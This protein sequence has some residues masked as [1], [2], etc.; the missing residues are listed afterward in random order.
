MALLPISQ[1]IK[2][3]ARPETTLQLLNAIKNPFG[4]VSTYVFT[5]SI[6]EHVKDILEAVHDGTGGGY[7]VLSEYGGGKTHFL[8]TVASLLSASD[9]VRDSIGDKEIRQD[10]ALVQGRRLL[11]V[12]FSLIGRAGVVNQPHAL[13]RILEG[14]IQE[15]VERNVGRTLNVSLAS[16]VGQWWDNLATPIKEAISRKC[17]ETRGSAAAEMRKD[18]SPDE[19]ADCIHESA[20]QLHIDIPLQVSPLGRLK[21]IYRQVVNDQTGYTGMLL[22]IDEFASWQDVHP[23]GAPAYSEDESLL[24]TLAE[25]LPKDEGLAVF[26]MVAS[27][28]PMPRKFQG[29]RFK[30]IDVLR[31]AGDETRTSHEYEMVVAER[32]RQLDDQRSPEIE[33]YYEAYRRRFVFARNLSPTDFRSI[34]PVQ[35]LCFD[36]LRRITSNLATA[37]IGINVLWDVLGQEVNGSPQVHPRVSSLTR[38][39]TAADL[40]ESDNL[41]GALT[42]VTYADAYKAYQ[43]AIDGLDRLNMDRDD[44]LPLARS[45]VRTAFL[46]HIARRGQMPMRLEEMAEAVV[47]DE[48]MFGKPEDAV[49]NVVALMQDMP[50]IKYDKAKREFAFRAEVVTGRPVSEILEQYKA[51]YADVHTLE[52]HWREQL[53]ASG[54]SDGRQTALFEKLPPN[55]PGKSAVVFRGVEYPGEEVTQTDWSGHLGQP[56]GFD[57][58]FRVVYLLRHTM[59]TAEALADDRII[60]GIPEELSDQHKEAL[61][62]L[63]ALDK[64]EEEYRHRQ[65]N[66]ALLVREFFHSKHSDF[67][68]AVLTAQRES[69]RKGAIVTKPNLAL[70]P[71]AVFGRS[72]KLEVMLG[73]LFAALFKD[74]PIGAFKGNRAIRM[75]TDV[76][77][78]FTGLWEASPAGKVSDALDNFAVGLGL[79]APQNPRRF[80]PSACPA[81]DIVRGLYQEARS[82]GQ[83][84]QV[85]PLYEAFARC[86]VPARIATLYLLCFVRRGQEGVELVLRE[87][88]KIRL[89]NG[90]PPPH[91]RISSSPV[92]NIV[93]NNAWA[94]GVTAFEA[95]AARSGRIWN[96]SLPWARKVAPELKTAIEPAD[97]ETQQELLLKS[98]GALRDKAES[99]KT[100]LHALEKQTERPVASRITEAL[101]EVQKICCAM[102]FE[103]L[104][105][106][107]EK[108]YANPDEFGDAVSTTGRLYQLSQACAAVAGAFHFLSGIPQGRL[109]GD[110]EVDRK[111]LLERLDTAALVEDPGRWPPVESTFQ[112]WKGRYH[113][114][115]RKFH[116]DYQEEVKKTD[117][118]R[119]EAERKLAAL[120]H[121]EQVPGLATE[122]KHPGLRASLQAVL[123]RLTRC[124]VDVNSLSLETLPH[125]SE[126]QVRY[127]EASQSSIGVV[128]SEID[129]AMDDLLKSF[130]GQAIRKLLEAS[131]EPGIQE[132]RHALDIYDKPRL[133]NLLQSAESVALLKGLLERGKIKV[134]RF[135]VMAHLARDYPTVSRD[136]LDAVV[137]KFKDLVEQALSQAEQ[138]SGTAAHVEVHLQ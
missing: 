52:Q 4:T 129:A 33:E 110:M 74:R 12:A 2:I 65:D 18:S 57:Q 122:K 31:T 49:L 121:L 6:K 25:T 131:T 61:R 124:T 14:E 5:P 115:Y 104:M 90:Q 132:F 79:A 103:D 70:D 133:V 9:K 68:T 71:G 27:Q 95:L 83:Y 30:E 88:H 36:I 59:V 108:Q 55:T 40:M 80:D 76:G 107:A 39:V 10:I 46:W 58:H 64:M 127:G 38:L 135:P 113:R 111:A 48:G 11:P 86:G 100:G 26:T 67:V 51:R 41:T 73:G 130:Q 3:R 96:D 35:P 72:D 50:Q 20:L 84:L 28:K 128:M 69:F 22:I 19:W 66:E 75:Q 116:R 17:E 102:S 120:D 77:N 126:C 125:C 137:Q 134:K 87:G 34:F 29:G 8:A 53:T 138:E 89:Q 16:E 85:K 45:V 78:I 106:A 97:V 24:Q 44:E 123:G 1:L 109:Q 15:S 81:F 43:Q 92:S 54:L 37:R 105:D 42:S 63:L 136:Q 99:A 82:K 7:W 47:A 93:W 101:D 117:S 91:G 21:N 60:V 23:E 98:A 13:Y 119:T 118:L 94:D 114:E 62:Q 32:V 112:A 56:L